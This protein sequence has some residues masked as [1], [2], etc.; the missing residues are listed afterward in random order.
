M[1]RGRH[2]G[3][4]GSPP[5][6]VDQTGV[7]ERDVSCLQPLCFR[8]LFKFLKFW[9]N[10]RH[11]KVASIVEQSI[12]V[13]PSASSPISL[14]LFYPFNS[15]S[16]IHIFLNHMRVS[17]RLTV[18]LP[19]Y[20]SICP[21]KI[22]P[23]FHKPQQ[24]NQ[25]QKTVN[26]IGRLE[27]TVQYTDH[28][29]ILRFCWSPPRCPA[30]QRKPRT[31]AQLL[32]TALQSPL[33]WNHSWVCLVPWTFFWHR[34]LKNSASKVYL[35]LPH[36]SLQRLQVVMSCLP[37]GRCQHVFALVCSYSWSLIGGGLVKVES[38]RFL[39]C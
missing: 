29:M 39:Q 30:W 3:S 6:H 8:N 9:P 37:L 11:R 4:P 22:L 26:N 5:D 24:N 16:T 38:A 34:H 36:N 15:S 2:K 27:A 28:S 10:F 7:L 32:V 1:V 14:H 20:M 25:N 31:S 23:W 21:T 17:L 33:I 35:T 18:S 19:L 13:C 12:P